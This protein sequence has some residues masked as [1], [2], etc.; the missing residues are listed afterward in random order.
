MTKGNDYI[1]TTGERKLLETLANPEYY[2]SSI[3]DICQVAGVSRQTYYE[4]MKKPGFLDKYS[5]YMLEIVKASVA[6]VIKA[7]VRFGTGEKANFQ[8]RKMLL[9]IGGIYTQRL[10]SEL[11]GVD[12]GPLHISFGVSR[13]KRAE[14]EARTEA[15]ADDMTGDDMTGRKETLDP[16]GE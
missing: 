12:G 1:P 2:G 14:V 9:E 6:D 5:Q 8:D 11:Q 10:V 13:P 4:A 15:G 7:T 3:T 16:G